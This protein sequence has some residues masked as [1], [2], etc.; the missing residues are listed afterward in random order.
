LTDSEGDAEDVVQEAALR[1]FRYFRTFSGGNG[2]AWFL[3]IVR[4]ICYDRYGHD[5][6]R[7]GDAFDEEKHTAPQLTPE[8]LL[9][10][11]EN[12]S[13][14]E[15]AMSELPARSRELLVLRELEGL[16]YQEVADALRIPIGTVMSG[17]SRARRALRRALAAE[18]D[19]RHSSLLAVRAG[20]SHSVSAH[21]GRRVSHR[22]HRSA[23]RSAWEAMYPDVVSFSGR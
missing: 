11:E 22:S 10:H 5:V 17:L 13:L 15:D 8:M 16:S 6:Q 23:R 4:H 9:L 7:A 14:I 19:R 1:A 2:R 18:V 21:R 20:L 3:R 12:V